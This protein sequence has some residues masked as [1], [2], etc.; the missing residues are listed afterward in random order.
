MHVVS[1]DWTC[2]SGLVTGYLYFYYRVISEFFSIIVAAQFILHQCF[3]AVGWAAG[4]AA[5]GL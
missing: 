1:R 5:S 3:D 4:R 2:L